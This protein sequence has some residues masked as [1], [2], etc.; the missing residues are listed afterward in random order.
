MNIIRKITYGII[1]GS[2]ILVDIVH[3]EQQNTL[4]ASTEYI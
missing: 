3:R 2:L 1:L 4:A